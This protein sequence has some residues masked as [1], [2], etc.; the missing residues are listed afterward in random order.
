[1]AGWDA[2]TADGSPIASGLWPQAGCMALPGRHAKRCT[3]AL[4]RPAYAQ[5]I[6][7]ASWG[8]IRVSRGAGSDASRSMDSAAAGHLAGAHAWWMQMQRWAHLAPRH[9]QSPATIAAL[10]RTPAMC[11]VADPAVCA[12]AVPPLKYMMRVRGK[13]KRQHASCAAAS[14]AAAHTG[15]L[16]SLP[17]STRRRGAV[18]ARPPARPGVAHLHPSAHGPPRGAPAAWRPAV[19][20][21]PRGWEVPVG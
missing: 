2:T 3:L 5:F 7:L 19:P 8:F 12:S 15:A 16:P 11:V 14:S 21:V 4:D 13:P 1:M 10:R 18:P 20:D 6:M 9:L 17:A